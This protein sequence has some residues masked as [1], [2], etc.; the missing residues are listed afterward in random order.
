MNT[1]L[2]V[3][4]LI[5]VTVGAGAGW[6]APHHAAQPNATTT[7]ADSKIQYYICPMHPN[8]HYDHP[9]NCPICGM[10]LVPVYADDTNAPALPECCGG[11]AS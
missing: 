2:I 4:A 10:T 3:I 7:T 9:G 8:I 6:L 1:K 11:A 5:A